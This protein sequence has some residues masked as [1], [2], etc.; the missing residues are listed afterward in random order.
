METLL[1]KRH[2]YLIP[3]AAG[4]II[5]VVSGFYFLALQTQSIADVNQ[6]VLT[7]IKEQETALNNKI[8]GMNWLW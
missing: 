2:K 3:V 1:F 6:F 5:L 7:H 4:I 8:D